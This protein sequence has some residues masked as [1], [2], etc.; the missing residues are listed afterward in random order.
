[1]A[2]RPKFLTRILD[3]AHQATVIFLLGSS[4]ALL[5]AIGA[6]MYNR[7]SLR[8]EKLREAQAAGY[9]LHGTEG[10]VSGSG[11]GSGVYEAKRNI[12]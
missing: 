7:R 4:V 10:S 2:G 9:D 11:S 12:D 1:M 6:N 8:L 5:G 3:T